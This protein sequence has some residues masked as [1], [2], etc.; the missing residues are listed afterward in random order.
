[1]IKK[2]WIKKT[3]KW[4]EKAYSYKNKRRVKG[5]G[6]PEKIDPIEKDFLCNI[7]KE[8]GEGNALDIGCGDGRHSIYLAKKGFN[9]TG[10]DISKN[11]ILI[12]RGNFAK[13]K[14]RGDFFN[15]NILDFISS[16]KFDLIIDYSVS[17]H[18]PV[19]LLKDY[20]Y[21][22][23]SLLKQNGY[24]IW[25][26]FS[27][28]DKDMPRKGYKIKNGQWFVFFD[29]ERLQ[30]LFSNFKLKKKQYKNLI[31]KSKSIVFPNKKHYLMLHCLFQK[32]HKN[33]RVELKT[34]VKH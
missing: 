10:V 25:V 23:N 18:V 8:S 14:L 3:K 33:Q 27:V 28:K 6:W 4:Y 2:P 5:Y 19:F 30:N 29:E 15:K 32:Q 12:T 21:T 9:V 13:N 26:G 31:L 7:M 24:F 16:K 17:T 1:M 22:I 34:K 11:A 20:A